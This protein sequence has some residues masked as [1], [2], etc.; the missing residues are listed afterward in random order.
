MQRAGP[1]GV[2]GEQRARAERAGPVAV[3]QPAALQRLQEPGGGGLRQAELV[4]Q[5]AEGA[6]RPG[7]DDQAEQCAGAFDGLA[8]RLRRRHGGPLSKFYIMEPLFRELRLL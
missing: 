3:H 7:L 5:R 1:G 6:R 8:A 4:D 2:Q